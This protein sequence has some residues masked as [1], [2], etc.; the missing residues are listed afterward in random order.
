MYIKDA[1][2]NVLE[3]DCEWRSDGVQLAHAGDAVHHSADFPGEAGRVDA[4]MRAAT[5][6]GTKVLGGP[7]RAAVALR[8]LDF[9]RGSRHDPGTLRPVAPPSP[10]LHG[11][12]ATVMALIVVVLL[13]SPAG[14]VSPTLSLSS[15]ALRIPAGKTEGQVRV[16]LKAENL[17]A[18]TTPKDDAAE[19]KDLGGL[20]PGETT[21]VFDPRGTL[22]HSDAT[23][24]AWLWTG[25]VARLPLNSTQRRFAR[26]AFGNTAQLVEYT[27]TNAAAGV[28][29]WSV[30]AP[31]TPWIVWQGFPGYRVSTDMLVA[32]GDW[33]AT[34]VR[35]AQSTL[36]DT[37]GLWSIGLPDLALCD[38]AGRCGTVSIG[39]RTART[40]HLRLNSPTRD[41]FT[42]FH[43]KYSGTLALAVDE[44]PEVQTLTVTVHASSWL[45]RVIGLVLLMLGVALWWWANVWVRARLLRLEA[46]KPVAAL[47]AEIGLLRA[48]LARVP[49]RSLAPADLDAKLGEIDGSLA[50]SA[51][52]ERNLLPPPPPKL[53]GDVSAALK[54]YLTQ[55][56]GR[57]TGIAV[58]TRDGLERLWRDWTEG[59]GTADANV[60][61]A[62][63]TALKRLDEDGARVTG[64]TDAKALVK[65][66]LATYHAEKAKVFASDVG[67]QAPPEPVT[68]Q[69]LT[70]EIGQLHKRSWLL[71]G[72]LTVLT[73]AWTLIFA[74]AGFGT[75]FDLLFCLFWGFGLP[76]TLEKL[77]QATPATIATSAGI[78]LP[79][80]G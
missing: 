4:F 74:N 48:R 3:I 45:A 53:G 19:L 62:L 12:R 51:L 66:V 64:E 30:T 10:I 46:L 42:W 20:E 47:R 43:G 27:I 28:F 59:S 24:R 57:V 80:A 17:T 29:T 55:L 63:L 78:T 21:V 73:G 35:L 13:A 33:P 31:A 58:V 49:D 8:S 75:V 15:A 52:D 16:L 65:D 2:G 60:K 61:K 1:E 7:R 79:K 39:P 11:A 23:G 14:A 34:N 37:T 40:L 70:W 54:A 50:T 25:N 26:L 41:A 67:R 76:T 38:D 56:A 44:R 6:T 72:A 36:R 69:E 71:W 22:V 5:T 68:V 9:A 77:Q 18:G 32:T